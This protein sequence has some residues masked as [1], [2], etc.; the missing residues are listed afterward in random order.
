MI[1]IEIMRGI[2]GAVNLGAV[3]L[4]GHR[5]VMG[6]EQ[7]QRKGQKAEDVALEKGVIQE[8]GTKDNL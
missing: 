5:L 1:G 7:R 6:R 4:L 2:I 3:D 8:K